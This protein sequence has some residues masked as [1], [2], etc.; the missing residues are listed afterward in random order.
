MGS[1]QVMGAMGSPP[2]VGCGRGAAHGPR[3]ALQLLRDLGASADEMSMGSALAACARA[4]GRW[5]E[6]LGVLVGL[7]LRIARPDATAFAMC[8]V[9]CER[10]PP[11]PKP[12]APL[13]R[14]FALGCFR[15][16]C[17]DRHARMAFVSSILEEEIQRSALDRNTVPR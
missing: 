6:A 11:P 14:C 4:G 2:A 10:A 5:L 3:Q 9:A 1:R 16:P 13:L 7:E 12:S 15:P 8:A 17:F